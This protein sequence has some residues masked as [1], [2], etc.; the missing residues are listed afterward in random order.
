LERSVAR[1]AIWSQIAIEERDEEVIPLMT[2]RPVEEL[3]PA[4]SP[5]EQQQPDPEPNSCFLVV[6]A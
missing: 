5:V 4:G 3:P 1:T 6:S 2:L